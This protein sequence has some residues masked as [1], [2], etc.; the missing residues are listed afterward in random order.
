MSVVMIENVLSRLA[1]EDNVSSHV[2]TEKR[3][4]LLDRFRKNWKNRTWLQE[5]R[6]IAWLFRVKLHNFDIRHQ[7]GCRLQIRSRRGTLVLLA[8]KQ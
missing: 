3:N 6:V 7:R 8:K 5:A 4:L 1:Y 2:V